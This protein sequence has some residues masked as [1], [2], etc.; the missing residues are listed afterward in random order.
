MAYLDID[1]EVLRSAVTT[2]QQTNDLISEAL[3]LLN[4][5]VI[6]ND[7]ACQERTQIN[8]NTITNRQKAMEIQKNTAA[9][10][11]AIRQSSEQFDEV[12]NNNVNRV[13]QVDNLLSQ[14]L[15]VVPGI[16]GPAAPSIVSFDGIKSSLEE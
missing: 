16:T 14:I 9:F 11:Q 7:W 3:S 8:A 15:S 1:T 2:A 4:Q 6:H 13:N 5:V 10:Y 12:E